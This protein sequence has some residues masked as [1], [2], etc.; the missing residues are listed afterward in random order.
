MKG[1]AVEIGKLNTEVEA[2][3]RELAALELAELFAHP[4][5]LRELVRDEVVNQARDQVRDILAVPPPAA[6]VLPGM[7]DAGGI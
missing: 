1:A 3:V 7:A 4:T 2:Q 6:P 5:R